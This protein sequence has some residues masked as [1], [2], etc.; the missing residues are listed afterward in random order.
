R[1]EK[2]ELE[3]M[4]RSK[5]SATLFEA[6]DADVFPAQRA[7]EQ[8]QRIFV[9]IF[10]SLLFIGQAIVAYSLWRSLAKSETHM[11][12]ERT[13]FSLA[14]FGLLALILFLLGR[15]S[16][17]IARLENHRLL[18]PS[19]GYLLLSAYVSV[20]VAVGI[21]LVKAE[22]PLADFYVAQGL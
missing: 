20:A 3:E 19:A 1:L 17:T 4:T 14:L 15:F 18:R 11:P 5:A 2:F 16:V 10:T 13:M 21:G 6:R 22:F 8:F 12:P 9:P 7:R